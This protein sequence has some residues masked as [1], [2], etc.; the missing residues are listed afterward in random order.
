MLTAIL[1]RS[2]LSL[3][4]ETGVIMYR[5]APDELQLLLMFCAA[6]SIASAFAGSD[7]SP[8]V[9]MISIKRLSTA[10]GCWFAKRINSRAYPV[11]GCGCLP[12]CSL[13]WP[14]DQESPTI[15]K[16]TTSGYNVFCEF[17]FLGLVT[18]QGLIQ[19]CAGAGWPRVHEYAE[20]YHNTPIHKCGR[21]ALSPGMRRTHEPVGICR[22]KS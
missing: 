7:D 20:L 13:S 17:Q 9:M 19:T 22:S 11:A 16:H 8:A 6:D 2:S 3:N 21:C 5:S 1:T 15:A 12:T 4:L 10:G 18:G 14:A